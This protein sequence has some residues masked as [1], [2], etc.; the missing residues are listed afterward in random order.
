MSVFC[1]EIS[2]AELPFS[3][4]GSIQS[5]ILFPQEDTVIGA[6]AYDEFA[7]TNTYANL[8]VTSR[9]LD[10][11]ARFEFLQYPLPGYEPDFKGWGVPNFF[12][13]GKYKSAKLTVGDFYDQFGS[14]LIFRTYEERNLGIDNSLRGVHFTAAPLTG[15]TVKL[16]GGQQRRYW[17]HNEGYVL[18]AD[19]EFGFENWFRALEKSNS[20][21]TLGTSFVSRR[22]DD[23]VVVTDATHRL[24]FP[25]DVAAYDVRLRFQKGDYSL[26]TEYA[27]KINDP[28]KDNGYI[29]KNGSALLV[30]ASYARS[31]MSLLLQTKRSDNMSFRSKRSQTLNSSFINHLPA[32]TNTQTYTLAALYPYATQPDG[33]WAFQGNFS[34]LFKRKT[35]LGG[36]Y[37]TTVIINASYIRNIDKQYVV[38]NYSPTSME[39]VWALRGTDGY[40]SDFFKMGKELYYQDVNVNIEKK[41]TDDFKLNLMYLYQYI[42]LGVVRKEIGVVKS[43]IFIMEEK[44][45]IDKNI[46]LRTELQYLYTKQDEG[47]WVYGT[48]ELSVLPHFM[49]TVSDMYNAGTTNLHYYKAMVTFTTGSH[50]IQA[51]YGRTRAGRDCS[52]GVC[53]DV[54]ASRGVTVSY[55]YNF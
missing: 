53:R 3:V 50:F 36:R 41:M 24:V 51:G 21:L 2:R 10:A 54:P 7:L 25:R 38:S 35:F 39:S 17:T 19:A 37:G 33:E 18:G 46:S 6:R 16:L 23:E 1:A 15:V 49:F 8:N 43:H 40:K 20:Y 48:A 27:G 32:F 4:H 26:L 5:D 34:Y 12:A 47:E 44:H 55:N 31:G 13:T 30:S 9:Y 52:G 28:S 45:Q 22:Q 29:Y 42:D 14:G 11:G